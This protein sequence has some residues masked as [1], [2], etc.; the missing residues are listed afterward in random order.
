FR[1]DA[2]RRGAGGADGGGFLRLRSAA[3]RSLRRAAR[4]KRRRRR[5]A[6]R[7]L[8][9][10]EEPR[11]RLAYTAVLGLALPVI[12]L[13]LWWRGRRE[14]G[15]RQNIGERLGR[16]ALPAPENLVWVHAVSV[17]EGRAAAPL[18]R[19]LQQALP[20]HG[21]LMT[22]TT[23]AGRETLKQVYGEA[24]Q[25]SFLPY[26]FPGSVQRF[27]ERF[28]ARLGAIM[29][30]EVWPNLVAACVARA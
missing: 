8:R 24:V 28:R 9:S 27:L 29:E 22:C 30:T 7:G 16:Y 3:H 2:S 26:D 25:V 13:R 5:Q 20:D 11:M 6:A 14:P 15:Y 1:P 19:R 10:A 12:R 4:E 23:A 21:F 17:G 18:V